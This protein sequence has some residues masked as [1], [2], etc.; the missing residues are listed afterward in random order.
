MFRDLLAPYLL[1]IK[2][3]GLALVFA[4][5]LA[6]GCRW[7][8]AARLEAEG[9]QATAESDRDGWRAQAEQRDRAIKEQ[10]AI[11]QAVQKA[12]AKEK[13]ELDAAV[14]R[15]NTAADRFLRRSIELEKQAAADRSEACN[16][17]A[18]MRVCG[19]PLR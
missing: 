2:L 16:E 17:I 9:K 18:R 10:N 12:A 3:L 19:S 11:S 4:A 1:W 8:K 15:A 7:N 5:G 13:A 6:G 14:V